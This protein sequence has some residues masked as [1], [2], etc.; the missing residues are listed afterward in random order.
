MGSG[1]LIMNNE[2]RRF[3]KTVCKVGGLAG[4]YSYLPIAETEAFFAHQTH[5]AD[6][7]PGTSWATWNETTEAGW[8][9]GANTFIVL[10]ENVTA[11]GNEIGQGA[12]LSEADR[13]LTQAGTAPGVPGATGSPPSRLLDGTSDHFTCTQALLDALISNANKTWSIIFKLHTVTASSKVLLNLTGTGGEAIYIEIAAGPLNFRL[14]QDGA[15]AE[16]KVTTDGVSQADDVY[17][18]F[19]ADG[20]EARAG[21]IDSG[22]PNG[23]TKPTKWSD[24]NANDRVQFTIYTGD[25]AGEA[26]DTA[27]YL[28]TL[29]V[30]YYFDCSAYYMV[31][32]KACLIVND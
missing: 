8:G 25:F 30:G 20:T 23:A 2:R 28:F 31:F 32:S 15:A 16:N 6:S 26:F 4:L 9:D 14:Q 3:L 10:A 1:R 13:T 5:S 29:N 7:G 19:W 27:Q 18:C 22:S 11:G 24:F 21:F 12:G 17:V